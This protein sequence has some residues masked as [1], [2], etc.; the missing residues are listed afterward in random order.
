MV[1]IRFENPSI[2]LSEGDSVADVAV[3]LVGQLA[4][5]LFVSVNVF[6]EDGTAAGIVGLRSCTSS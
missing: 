2:S 3:V 5:G 4:S 1:A 6:T